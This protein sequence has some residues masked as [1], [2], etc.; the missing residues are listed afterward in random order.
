MEERSMSG[1]D[2]EDCDPPAE[3]VAVL[4]VH[5]LMGEA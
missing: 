5:R 2:M 1:V 3:Q 4:I